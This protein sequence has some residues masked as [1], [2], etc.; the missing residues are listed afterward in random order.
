MCLSRRRDDLPQKLRQRTGWLNIARLEHRSIL[1]TI[2]RHGGSMCAPLLDVGC[3][4]MP[5]RH[6]F[7]H[8]D[9]YV[10]VD[11]LLSNG[12]DIVSDACNLPFKSD[13]FGTVLSTQVLFEIKSPEK[14]FIEIYRV[15]QPGGQVL[16]T[17]VQSWGLMK[18]PEID[19]WR[20]TDNGIRYLAESAGFEVIKIEPRGGKWMLIGTRLSSAIWSSL[21]SRRLSRRYALGIGRVVC[22]LLQ[23]LFDVLDK[24]DFDPGDTL[25]WSFIGRRPL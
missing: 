10:G 2:V 9:N 14:F 1:D 25:G 20:F 13:V 19:Y 16:M 11:F 8:I 12:I 17:D 23:S 15:L 24:I 4:E 3:G 5:Y 22:A 6:L 21:R 7:P 18:Y